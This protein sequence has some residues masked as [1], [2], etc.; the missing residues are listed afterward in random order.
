[1]FRFKKKFTES[2][3]F[4]FLSVMFVIMVITAFAAS[5][6]IAQNERKMLK[7]SLLDKGQSLGSYI[8]KL[9]KDPLIM[10]DYIQLDAI[11]KDITK[12]PEVAYATVQ[13]ADG[14]VLTSL[15]ASINYQVP[16]LKAAVATAPKNSELPELIAAIKKSGI[17]VDYAVPIVIEGDVLGTITMGMSDHKIN[18]QITM[19][20]SYILAVNLVVA[21]LLGGA[22]YAS[23]KK[24]ILGPIAKLTELSRRIAQGEIFQKIEVSSHD[25]IGK[26][27]ESFGDMSGY[28]KNIGETAGEISQG[29]LRREVT[30]RSEHDYLG[31]SFQKMM[32]GLQ[33]I[34]SRV[35]Q[36]SQEISAASGQL[37]SMA[38][39]AS[40][41]NESAAAAIEEIT[42]TMHEMAANT[43]SV[44]KNTMSQASSVNETSSSIEQMIVS[45]K[46]VA[47]N[48]KRLVDIS[49]KSRDAVVKGRLA[50]N[51]SAAGMEE[52]NS[53]ITRVADTVSTLSVRIE[54]IG[55]IVE[56]I[57]D[58]AE[59][60]NLLAL[61]AAIEAAK[62]GDQGLGFAVVADEVRKLAERSAV[63]TKEINDLI[64]GIQKEAQNAVKHMDT[65]LQSVQNELDQG[66]KEVASTLAHIEESVEEVAKYSA[67]IGIA[68]S[69]QSAGGDQII[70]AI[71]T[72]NDLTQNISASSEEQS[73]GVEQ[74]V[75]SIERIRDMIQ[76]NASG[77]TE[78]S[79]SADQLATQSKKLR[80]TVGRFQI[81]DTADVAMAA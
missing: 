32:S 9:S 63:S 30:R 47:E 2:I 67:E 31:E 60:T 44:A 51:K 45:I 37:A 28:L 48:V 25:E 49:Q 18:R 35:R 54:D 68:T 22:L 80:E 16:G 20:V 21:F 72:L 41:N 40:K 55:R 77:S 4:K 56:V 57:D 52:I 69:E 38:E 73:A 46:R 14:K 33:N 65:S 36:N 1:M 58:I 27:M 39:E 53:A 76:Q 78:L 5:A 26:L 79:A 23:S 10:K 74:V 7:Q 11:V 43:S 75:K 61:N 15:Y 81:K 70:K 66:R 29:E 19:T 12:D 50:V 42:A 17:V 64:R 62:A 71:S 8:A 24:I 6:F 3:Q 34:V 59:Q 13:D